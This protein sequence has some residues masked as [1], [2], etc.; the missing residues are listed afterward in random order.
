[1]AACGVILF[2]TSTDIKT[3]CKNDSFLNARIFLRHNSRNITVGKC[4]K[5]LVNFT[6]LNTL[7]C[8]QLFI[9]VINIKKTRL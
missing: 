1:M 6:V 7:W 2:Y 9:Y 8:A 5:S 4:S 3:L